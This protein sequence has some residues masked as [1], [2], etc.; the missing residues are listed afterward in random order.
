[1]TVR[2]KGRP[3]RGVAFPVVCR[4]VGDHAFHRGARIP[5]RPRAGHLIAARHR[6]RD[7]IRIKQQRRRVVAQPGGRIEGAVDPPRVDLSRLHVGHEHMPEIR[8]PVP[9]RVQRNHAGRPRVIDIVE[10]Q[11]VQPCSRAGPHREVGAAVDPMGAQWRGTG[12]RHG[13]MDGRD[14]LADA[15]AVLGHRCPRTP[16]PTRRR[17]RRA[18]RRRIGVIGDW[19]WLRSLKLQGESGRSAMDRSRPRLDPQPAVASI[20]IFNRT[21]RAFPN[22]RGYVLNVQHT[23]PPTCGPRNQHRRC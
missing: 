3:S 13:R 5:A 14:E 23:P 8:R 11:Q 4:E 17:R 18:G 6:H 1:M 9:Q 12:A 7:A 21:R 15:F 16:L 2:A 20:A 22:L 10:Q 19:A